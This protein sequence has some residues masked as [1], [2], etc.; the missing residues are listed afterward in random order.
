MLSRLRTFQDQGKLEA[1]EASF[2]RILAAA[3]DHLHAQLG[4]A[5]CSW[6]RGDRSAA[7]RLLAAALTPP[8]RDANQ[9]LDCAELLV[10][11]GERAEARRLLHPH[12]GD[13]PK[14][15][16]RLGQIAEQDGQFTAAA[17][18]YRQALEAGGVSEPALRGLAL[19]LLRGG[20]REG[21]F[22][23]L[24]RWTEDDPAQAATAA[25]LRGEL[26]RTLGEAPAA[27]AAFR[28]ALA[29]QPDSRARH[30]DLATELRRLRRFAEAEAVLDALSDAA[31]VRLARAELALARQDH[32]AALGHV[33]A[34]LA[35]GPET[36]VA[37][38]LR[39][40]I[41]LDRRDAAAAFAAAD[42]MAALS[43]GQ[44]RVTAERCRL[45]AYRSLGREA[46]ALALTTRLRAAQPLDP[47]AALD[48]LRQLR[49]M[50]DRAG[51]EAALRSALAEHPNHPPLLI[52]GH[53]LALALEDHEAALAFARALLA[54]QPEVS[55]HHLRLLPLLQRE[56]EAQ[57]EAAWAAVLARFPQDLSVQMEAVRRLQR[58]GLVDAAR[59]Q[60]REVFAAHPA[61][62]AAWSLV[63]EL[64]ITGGTAAEAAALLPLAP[65][66][67]GQ[68]AVTVL[69]SRARLARRRH[70]G[71]AAREL[72]HAALARA[73]QNQGLLHT[74]FT[75]SLRRFAVT[76][77]EDCVRRLAALR[78]PGRRFSQTAIGLY[79]TLE[80]QMLNDILLDGAARTALEALL[81]L[82]PE[83]RLAGLLP[84]M[85]E[86]PDHLPTATQIVIAL[87]EA[88]ALAVPAVDTGA[89][90]AIPALISQ[91]WHDETPP[92]DVAEVS[93]T[94]QD[95]NPGWT[96]RR[97]SHESARA[98][99]AAAF[100]PVVALA[101][102]RAADPTTRADL[103]RLAV[104]FRDG[105]VWADMDDRC[106]QPLERLL[107]PGTE[108]L[109]W[110]EP[111]GNLGNN[112]IAVRPQHPVLRRAL[113]LAVEAIN[114][115]DRDTVWMLTGPGLLTRAFATSLA[116]AAEGWRDWLRPM[117]ILDEFELWQ[118]V[119]YHCQ[120]SYKR[121]GRH[122]SKRL[123]NQGQATPRLLLD[124]SASAEMAPVARLQEA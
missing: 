82:P 46:E 102:R 8:P 56:D 62:M 85:R 83:T 24:R 93:A 55:A 20:D 110:Q 96:H 114:R 54:H 84:L 124:P 105:G 6:L 60:A 37:L 101:Y 3:P 61:S 18:Y 65:A 16:E 2:R 103:L 77:A 121:A 49:R 107:P 91:Y 112:V 22:A 64:T 43:G 28:D 67:N 92:P 75:L 25:R 78:E 52:E 26:H 119:A 109:F 36:L 51:A 97:F 9:L 116:E 32:A 71:A 72:L 73:P 41:A 113:A 95:C 117:R 33:D 40:R 104:L 31:E 21:A 12:H 48:H 42:G 13:H 27:V 7:E 122:W 108:A 45:E 4:L 123:F 35:G 63:Y 89:P 38:Q 81:P 79:Q 94:W 14:L 115:G 50:G 70:Q 29:L 30:I 19:A 87:R 39:F 66:Q 120:L 34:A 76:E 111:T 86:R 98:Y 100:P 15:A 88:G 23:A 68:D 58:R 106:L 80:G 53:D 11:M 5:G 69:H 17:G 57:A 74:L 47:A 44:H 118:Q 90:R 99:L 10:A 59:V 1:A